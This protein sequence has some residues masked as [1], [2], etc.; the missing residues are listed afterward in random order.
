MSGDEALLSTALV[1]RVLS[2]LEIDAPATDLSG[3]SALYHAWCRKVPF[4]NSLKLI[5]VQGN[6]PGPLAGSKPDAFFENWLRFGSGGTCW[7]GNGALYALLK[8]LGFDACRGVATMM[9]APNLPPNHGTVVV[10]IQDCR[11]LVDASILHS[12]PLLLDEANPPDTRSQNRAWGVR[13][14]RKDNNFKVNWLPLHMT[15]GMDCRLDYFQATLED[16]AQR[17]ESTRA[18]SPF[19]YE[20]YLRLIKGDSVVGIAQG[21]RIEINPLGKF[22]ATPL[23]AADR[24]SVLVDELGIHK[25]LVERIPVDSPTPPPPGSKT[26]LRGLVD[27]PTVQD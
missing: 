10:Q 18:W 1:K 27:A 13:L 23:N 5:D 11:Y 22:H 15:D 17:Y 20:L 24:L 21:K 6:S 12:G 14:H 7:S 4:D 25:D 26:A 2:K 19:N 16:F 9:A 3:I 8:A